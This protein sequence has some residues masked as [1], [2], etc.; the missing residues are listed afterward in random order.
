MIIAAPAR[1][2]PDPG[3]S[4]T[5]ERGTMALELTD[6]KKKARE[7][8]QHAIELAK[9]DGED[10]SGTEALLEKIKEM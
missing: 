10:Y 9:R 6:E 4:K 2:P 5:R 7:A 8:A 3:K 1:R